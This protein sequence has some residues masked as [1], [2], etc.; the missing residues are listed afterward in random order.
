M[1]ERLTTEAV[2]YFCVDRFLQDLIGARALKTAFDLRV[3]DQLVGE[4]AVDRRT[5]CEASEIDVPGFDL[6][7]DL[8][9]VNQVVESSSTR[10]QL[11][12]P[13][14]FALKYRDL[15]EAK[16]DF[17]LLV[18]SDLA[19]LFTSLIA[20]PSQFMEQARI[21]RLFDYQRCFELTSENYELTKRWMHFTSALTRYE[22]L[23]V[24]NHYDFGQHR[25]MLDIGGNSGEFLLQICRRHAPLRG[26]VFDLPVVCVVGQEHLLQQP[27]MDRITF[28]KGSAIDDP[29]P[30]GFDS[31]VFKSMLHD[32]PES[33]T[34]Q[35]LS[36]AS[37]ALEPGGTLLI[38]ERGPLPTSEL[39]RFSMLPM[40]LFFRSFRGP[41]VYQRL[42][43]EFGL[44]DITV[45]RIDLEMPFFLLTAKKK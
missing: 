35:M 22:T 21:F 41:E 37:Q 8:L 27:E 2:K 40:L 24:M 25:R 17:G 33:L 3:I 5:L 36:K 34:R 31:I 10:I 6:L 12:E 20:T 32:W 16:L 29:F 44:V 18:T 7:L 11:T 45:Q 26:T 43:S 38:F 13:F 1:D 15:L 9:T 39:S 19:D 30:A 23:A 42:L 4:D 28:V 14:A